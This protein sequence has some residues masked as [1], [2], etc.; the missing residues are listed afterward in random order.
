[1][2]FGDPAVEEIHRRVSVC[3]FPANIRNFNDLS[4]VLPL[5]GSLLFCN[6]PMQHKKRNASFLC[7]LRVKLKIIE[8]IQIL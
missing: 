8:L 6:S 3:T 4:L 1:M 2:K 7:C 5:A